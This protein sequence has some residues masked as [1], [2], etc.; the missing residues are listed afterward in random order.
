MP[1][2]P[3]PQSITAVRRAP[4]LVV[5]PAGSQLLQH[6]ECR[7]DGP[8]TGPG[9][10]AS[11]IRN[12][13]LAALGEIHRTQ[14]IAQIEGDRLWHINPL[15]HKP[16]SRKRDTLKPQALRTDAQAR[17]IEEVPRRK[18]QL[19]IAIFALPLRLVH[20]GKRI[21]GSDLA[22]HEHAPIDLG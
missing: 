16:S 4:S 18:R 12:R 17:P 2:L 8:H 10:R 11:L 5:I 22:V 9:A 7:G 14:S 3:Q 6:T 1:Q 19:A 15:I 13:K 20:R 21:G